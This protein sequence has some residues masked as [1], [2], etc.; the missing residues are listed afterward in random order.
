MWEEKKLCQSC[1]IPGSPGWAPQRRAPCPG[2]WLAGVH[3]VS[4]GRPSSP[5]SADRG[6]VG[7]WQGPAGR[8]GLGR[9]VKGEN[10]WLFD[11][12]GLEAVAWETLPTTKWD[13]GGSSLG[14]SL[15]DLHTEKQSLL[16]LPKWKVN[17]RIK[18]ADAEWSSGPW[19]LKLLGTEEGKSPI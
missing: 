14:S 11:G 1:A 19:F 18:R 12:L 10:W 13:R 17:V 4:L 7:W 8:G 15:T 5:P 9:D 6:L 3:G 16:T 2:D